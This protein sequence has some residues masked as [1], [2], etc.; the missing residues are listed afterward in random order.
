VTI[1]KFKSGRVE[2]DRLRANVVLEPWVLT[3]PGFDARIYEG[4]LAGS[5]RFDLTDPEHPQVRLDS[6]LD[7]ARVERLLGTWVPPGQWLQGSLSTALDV[8]GDLSDVQRS[9]TASGLAAVWNGTLANLPVLDELASFTRIP[10]LAQVTFKDLRSSFRVERGR[11]TTG[12]AHISSTAGD[13]TVAGSVGLDG[14]LDYV[15]SITLPPSV[16]KE[17]GGTA[18]LAAGALADPQGRILLDLRIG[19]TTR[20][21]KIALDSKATADRVRG[22]LSSA[23]AEQQKKLESQ[24]RDTLAAL[25]RTGGDSARAMARLRQKSL[26]DSLLK[27]AGKL[28]DGFFKK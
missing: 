2:M 5:A 9:L 27:E 22:Q 24:A 6:K 28:L 14:S 11:V 1:G 4:R 21:P 16:L 15:T 8:T 19:G 7:S 10:S 13:W 18:A 25:A 26:E 20:N 12:P 17:L 23:L 3:S